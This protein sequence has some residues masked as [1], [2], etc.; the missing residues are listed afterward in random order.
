MKRR[1]LLGTT[2]LTK[3]ELVSSVLSPLGIEVLLPQDL[4]FAPLY[5]NE[6][7]TVQENARQK[8][9]AYASMTGENILAI[10]N[11]LYLAGLADE[12]QPG[13]HVRR[14]PGL[15]DR[16]SDDEM[17]TYYSKLLQ[18]LRGRVNGYWVFA[19]CVVAAGRV[20]EKITRMQRVFVAKPSPVILPGFPLES[21]QIDPR[22]GKYVSELPL[23]ARQAFW[24]E[25]V[26]AAIQEVVGEALDLNEA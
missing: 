1:I 17:L 11:A 25:Y 5:V 14:I 8:A 26:G 24:R 23:A 13:T 16:P 9:L 7:G 4:G 20:F 12:A 19:I 2:N 21:L 10:D 15:G 22:S 6:H 18:K 3:R